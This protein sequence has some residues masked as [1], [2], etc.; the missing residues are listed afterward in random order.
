MVRIHL[1]PL[2]DLVPMKG[3]VG[4]KNINTLEVKQRFKPN[5]NNILNYLAK[6]DN[7]IVKTNSKESNKNFGTSKPIYESRFYEQHVAKNVFL[8]E[9][10]GDGMALMLNQS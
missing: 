8:L 10:R 4:L 6:I 9:R 5:K 3:T 7:K 1:E 2:L